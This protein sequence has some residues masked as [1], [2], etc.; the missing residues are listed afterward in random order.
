MVFF[1]FTFYMCLFFVHAYIFTCL[2][3][4]WDGN[5]KKLTESHRVLVPDFEGSPIQRR[6]ASTASDP[7]ALCPGLLC[8]SGDRP[9]FFP[10]EEPRPL[11]AAGAT[12]LVCGHQTGKGLVWGPQGF[13]AVS[14]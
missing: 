9:P 8:T 6:R 13:L 1:F 3:N 5:S 12:G 7:R 11:L 4:V 2:S 14:L 10:P